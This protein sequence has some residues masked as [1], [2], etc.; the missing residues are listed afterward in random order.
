WRLKVEDDVVVACVKT[1]REAKVGYGF[2][3]IRLPL[4]V[5]SH[6]HVRPLAEFERRL[7]VVPKIMKLQG[8]E[9][10]APELICSQPCLDYAFN[11]TG[12]TSIRRSSPSCCVVGAMMLARVD[13]LSIIVTSSVSI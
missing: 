5:V 2:D 11:R 9:T 6:E 4:A 10:H 3:D 12:I 8:L 13:E 1:L 7:K